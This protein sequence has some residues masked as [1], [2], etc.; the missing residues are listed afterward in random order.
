[1]RTQSK[2]QVLHMSHEKQHK[3]LRMGENEEK[4][5]IWKKN[6]QACNLRCAGGQDR[7]SKSSRPAW[8]TKLGEPGQPSE[9]LCQKEL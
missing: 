7:A 6:I 2:E 1:M 3:A 5:N 8:A 9:I 4:G